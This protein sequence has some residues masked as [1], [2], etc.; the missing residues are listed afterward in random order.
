MSS[1]MQL[2]LWQRLHLTRAQCNANHTNATF[3]IFAFQYVYGQLLGSSSMANLY[4]GA[5][6]DSVGY[7][8]RVH[9]RFRQCG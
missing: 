2:L 3:T 4:S 1:C 7:L 5:D 6:S 8:D 9:G